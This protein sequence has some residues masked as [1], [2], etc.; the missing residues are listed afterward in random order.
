MSL[1]LSFIGLFRYKSKL[2]AHHNQFSQQP[3]M[4]IPGLGASDR[5]TRSLRKFLT[6]SGLNVYGWGQGF[7][8]G[9]VGKLLSGIINNIITISRKHQ[10]PVTL[11]GW[12]LGG[13][14]AREVAR[15]IPQHIKGVSCMGSPLTGGPKNTLYASLYKKLG[16]DLEKT[17]EIIHKRESVPLDVPCHI[18]YSKRDGIVHWE[19]CLDHHNDHT[20]HQEIKTPHFSMGTSAEVFCALGDWLK[21]T[22]QATPD[23]DRIEH[24]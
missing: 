6:K 4:V 16:H 17:A 5:S 10:Q 19:A 12:S 14:I 24:S 21:K 7:N 22:L 23:S 11:I 20:T 18:L 2:T 3:V 9:R 1:P 8:N 15:Q 13:L